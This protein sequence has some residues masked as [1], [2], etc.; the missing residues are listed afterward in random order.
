MSTWIASFALL[1]TPHLP[2]MQNHFANLYEKHKHFMG[3]VLGHS[4]NEATETKFYSPKVWCFPDETLSW[5]NL[6]KNLEKWTIIKQDGYLAYSHLLILRLFDHCYSL[7]RKKKGLKPFQSSVTFY[8]LQGIRSRNYRATGL[9]KSCSCTHHLGC[10]RFELDYITKKVKLKKIFTKSIN[11]H[12][13][14][15]NPKLLNVVSFKEKRSP[16]NLQ[17]FSNREDCRLAYMSITDTQVAM[18]P[19]LLVKCV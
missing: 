18:M 10:L 13:V 8:I 2:L 16:N 3:N 17:S 19:W 5:V 11:L 9:K 14:C 7:Q 15:H 1:T 12:V 4:Y 6:S